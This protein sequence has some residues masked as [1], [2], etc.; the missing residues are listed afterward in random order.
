MDIENYQERPAALVRRDG[1][2]L[3]AFVSDT[4]PSIGEALQVR[5]EN[6]DTVYAVVRRHTGGR[7]VDA[8]LLD[9]PDWVQP[10]CTVHATGKDAHIPL[11]G[12]G[13][14]SFNALAISPAGDNTTDT[15]A[16]RPRTVE[17]AELNGTRLTVPTGFPPIDRLAAP[18]RGG[19]NL[20]LDASPNTDAFDTICA[21]IATHESFDAKLQ[22]ST[23]D[24]QPDWPT[25]HLQIDPQSPRQITALRVLSNWA[26]SLRDRGED[27]LVCAEL[28][29]LSTPGFTSPEDAAMGTSIGEVIDLLGTTLS[30]TNSA[31]ITTVIR[32]PLHDSA[33]GIDAIIETMSLGEVDAQIFVDAD[34][35]F[36]PTRSTSR[37]ELDAGAQSEQQRL[38]RLLS[39]ARAAQDKA[40][41]WGEFGV[42]DAELEAIEQAKALRVSLVD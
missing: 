18:A 14:T 28:P 20:V 40:A 4:L 29:P 37:A 19:V 12:A 39:R 13:V 11:P 33:A 36:E 32:L 31:T 16:F 38:L 41:L 9:A 26:A 6:G 22:L 24:R 7:E 15:F 10:G 21:R 8:L 5:A 1:D 30:S 23:P 3:R 35:R 27:L 42:N 34:G 25:H 17:F 2:W